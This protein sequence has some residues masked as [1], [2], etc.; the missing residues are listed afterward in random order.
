MKFCSS[1]CLVGLLYSTSPSPPSWKRARQFGQTHVH[2]DSHTDLTM[3]HTSE[4]L[5]GPPSPPPGVENLAD[6]VYGNLE[7]VDHFEVGTSYNVR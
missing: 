6:S 7:E 5:E 1:R 2:R 3:S 4:I